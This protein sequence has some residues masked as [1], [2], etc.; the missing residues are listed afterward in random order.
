MPDH[1]LILL[2]AESGGPP[3]ATWCVADGRI[4]AL[5]AGQDLAGWRGRITALVPAAQAP[6]LA[7]TAQETATADQAL[8]VARLAAQ[9][10]AL[11][12]GSTAVAGR[13]DGQVVTTLVASQ[14]LAAWQ[15]EVVALTGR[16][17][18]A[19]LPAGLL[20]PPPP[21]GTVH[22]ASLGRGMV[23]ARTDQAAFVAEAPLWQALVPDGARVVDWAER[24]LGPRLLQAHA[25][26]WLDMQGGAAGQA[27]WPV[28]RLARLAVLVSV[29][30]LAVPVAQIVRWRVDAARIAA[31][32]LAQVRA[33]FP[34]VTDLASA[35]QAVNAARRRAQAGADGWA[36]PTAAL[37][38]ALRAAPG[39]RLAGL[40]HTAQ[41]SL[42][43]TLAARETALVDAVL[44][45]LQRDGWRLAQ[46]PAPVRDG[47]GIVATIT[48]RAP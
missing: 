42:R 16:G 46:P 30:A 18:D 8:A 35:E 41:G 2:L 44:L 32:S 12:P 25:A 39:V 1:G 27:T 5:P 38:Q 24:D 20:L 19:V 37:W 7:L 26:P 47:A 6:V 34:A 43:F 28:R 31:A 23:L 9:D 3:V 22:R 13:D 14:A 10:H 17:A 33:R 4:D 11:A 40:Q 36:P 29:L 48:M 21:A 45:A 15:G